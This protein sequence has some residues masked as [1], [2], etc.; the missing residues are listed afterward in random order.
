MNQE[1]IEVPCPNCLRDINPSSKF[2]KYCGQALIQCISCRHLNVRGNTFCANCGEQIGSSSDPNKPYQNT[3]FSESPSTTSPSMPFIPVQD[4]NRSAEHSPSDS[5]F[6]QQ[7]TPYY[8]RINHPYESVKAVGFLTGVIP[9]SYAFTGSLKAIFFSV[10]TVSIGIVIF[11][12]SFVF[13]TGAPFLTIIGALFAVVIMISAP[14]LGFYIVC[15]NWLY[16]TFRIKNPVDKI[17]I[18]ANFILT[19]TVFSLVSLF[20]FP[21]LL[22]SELWVSFFVVFTFIYFLV[23]MF[24]TSVKAFLADLVYVKAVVEQ[25]QF[26]SSQTENDEIIHKDSTEHSDE[27]SNSTIIS[28][29]DEI[30]EESTNSFSTNEEK[31]S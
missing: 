15:S 26:V 28:E 7:E 1:E 23:I 25:K 6:M 16:R 29:T 14:F 22:L 8:P 5:Y 13:I 9:N 27:N 10:L 19:I 2:C 11:G 12:L 20:L 30:K 31:D 4:S 3:T 21:L 24:F 18:F 17:N